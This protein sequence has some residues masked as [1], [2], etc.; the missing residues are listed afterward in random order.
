MSE[1]AM[2]SVSSHFSWVLPEQFCCRGMLRGLPDRLH[3]EG[4]R[5]P[6]QRVQIHLL[7]EVGE[8]D[9]FAGGDTPGKEVEPFT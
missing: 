2:D 9:G 8:L 4:L 3:V 1:L 7:L 6:A 5:R